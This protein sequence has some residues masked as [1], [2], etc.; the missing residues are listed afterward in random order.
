MKS[1]FSHFLCLVY[2]VGKTFAKMNGMKTMFELN[3]CLIGNMHACQ[4]L[5][6]LHCQQICKIATINSA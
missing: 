3:F 5:N 2:N 6:V 1:N 4:Y